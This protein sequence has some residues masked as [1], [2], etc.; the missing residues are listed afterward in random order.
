M[1]VLRKY[2]RTAGLRLYETG[3][4]VKICFVD[5]AL[6]IFALL[7]LDDWYL[8]EL[9]G[10]PYSAGERA[11]NTAWRLSEDALTS[12]VGRCSK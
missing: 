11:R 6:I 5:W 7:G 3:D 10:V 2:G 9:S 1:L 8:V 12:V 4:G